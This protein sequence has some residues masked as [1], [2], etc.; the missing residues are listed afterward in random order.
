MSMNTE[1]VIADYEAVRDRALASLGRAEAC[2]PP[3]DTNQR[4]NAAV[5]QKC[6]VLLKEN[7]QLRAELEWTKALLSMYEISRR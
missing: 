4:D 2:L 6:A 7:A 1:N 5:R 3:A